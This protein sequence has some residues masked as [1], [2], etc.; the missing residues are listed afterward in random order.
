MMRHRSPVALAALLLVLLAL[1]ALRPAAAAAQVVVLRV[2]P[3]AEP[4]CA[5][6][7]AA[8]S[9]FG[10]VPDP[11]HFAEAQRRGLDPSGDEA[12]GTLTP[13]LRVQLAVVPQSATRRAAVVEFRDGR[14]G[15]SLGTASIGLSNR[16][17]SA[18][19]RKRLRSAVARRLGLEQPGGGPPPPAAEPEAEPGAPPADAGAEPAASEAR[20]LQ[21]RVFAG[22]GMGT[23]ALEWPMAGERIAVDTGAFAAVDLGA[24]LAFAVSDSVSLGPEFN[25]QT[26]LDHEI[27]ELHIAGAPESMGVRSHRF[28]ALIVPAFHFG[29]D[30]GWQIAPALGY[31]VRN[32]RPD[33]HHLLTPSSSIGGPLLR[34][35]LR[36]PFGKRLGLRLGPEA[37]WVLVGDELQELGIE[38][39]GL[40]FG[41]DVR[42]EI[43]IT[44]T[45]GVELT[46]REAH[47]MLPSSQGDDATDVERY[48]T[49]RL[50][51]EL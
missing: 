14:S 2:D 31:G 43:A 16:D 44:D 46:Y 3:A 5:A 45:L 30:S 36:I 4:L 11:G 28:E 21:M 32:L 23:R 22:A 24:S 27:T 13:L 41:A 25:Y 29:Q 10:V 20:A 48:A 34:L 50:S 49:A 26:S 38:S 42:F 12:L 6:F 15:A 47:A 1:A 33:V 40:G 7:E 19:G 35:V 51:G 17:L 8:L 18:A 9:D 39:S 37:Q